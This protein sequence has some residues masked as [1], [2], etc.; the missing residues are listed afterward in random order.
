MPM[1]VMMTMISLSSFCVLC[2]LSLV[3]RRKLFISTLK[4]EAV[5]KF[6]QR[7]CNRRALYVRC[8]CCYCWL[9]N[10]KDNRIIWLPIWF[11]PLPFRPRQFS[12]FSQPHFLAPPILPSPL[13]SSATPFSSILWLFL[14]LYINIY[15]AKSK[16]KC[17]SSNFLLKK[18]PKRW[19]W[20]IKL[21][22]CAMVDSNICRYYSSE[23]VLSLMLLFLFIFCLY[24]PSRKTPQRNWVPSKKTPIFIHKIVQGFDFFF[25]SLLFG[26]VSSTNLLIFFPLSF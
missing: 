23:L 24:S 15:I 25:I 21:R 9:W 14:L 7:S 13:P 2:S 6:S 20:F 11:F 26:R 10:S 17:A 19:Y 5:E 8:E 16:H 18:K 22:C 12:L 3:L 4:Y 1:I